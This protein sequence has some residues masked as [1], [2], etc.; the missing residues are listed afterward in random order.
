[1]S[2]RWCKL[3]PHALT[4]PLWLAVA[5][6]AGTSPGLV[7]ATFVELLTWTTE[8][9]PD[10]GSIA[11]FDPRVWAAW[12]RIAPEAVERIIASLRKFGRLAGD[13]IANWAKRQ[14]SAAVGMV[15]ANVNKIAR[16]VSTPRVRKHRER[17]RQGEML[18]P[19]AGIRETPDETHETPDE[20]HETPPETP[21]TVNFSMP[22]GGNADDP[23]D[24]EKERDIDLEKK[25]HTLAKP[26]APA[27]PERALEFRKFWQAY[28]LRVKKPLAWQAWGRARTKAGEEVILAG[29]ERYRRTKP[30]WQ[31]WAHPSTWLDGE[32]WADELLGGATPQEPDH[33][34]NWA[35]DRH[36]GA[37]VTPDDQFLPHVLAKIK[38]REM[39]IFGSIAA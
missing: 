23:P 11:G 39:T 37:P 27:W 21:N 8:H 24:I 14:G 16:K 33:F 29:V 36:G 34:E 1:M 30:D 38:A 12:L 10:T 26:A 5:D 15:A 28:P 17:G 7:G 3:Y 25:T 20:T 32:R 19:L 18:L 6:D 9:A 2:E 22:S 4:D 13:T 31:Q 35:R